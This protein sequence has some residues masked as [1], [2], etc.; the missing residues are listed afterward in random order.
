VNRRILSGEMN[1]A[2]Q[3]GDE[4]PHS[5]SEGRRSEARSS[6]I[7]H[8]EIGRGVIAE[9]YFAETYSSSGSAKSPDALYSVSLFRSVRMLIFSNSAAFVRLPEVAFNADKMACFSN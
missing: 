6:E 9:T 7:R 1:F 5:M 8:A 4:S 2:W 3:G